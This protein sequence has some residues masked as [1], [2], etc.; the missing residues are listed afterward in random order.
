MITITTEERERERERQSQ[1]MSSWRVQGHRLKDD[2][3]EDNLASCNSSVSFVSSLESVVYLFFVKRESFI[4][5]LT[6]SPFLLFSLIL[7]V[8]RHLFTLVRVI[9]NYFH[10]YFHF[11]L[12]FSLFYACLSL[13]DCIYYLP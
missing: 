13:K 3:E 11:E 9:T 5:F 8:T 7:R 4:L 6:S 2:N 10:C 12:F 1:V